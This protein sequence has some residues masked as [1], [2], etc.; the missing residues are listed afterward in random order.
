MSKYYKTISFDAK[1]Q[2]EAENVQKAI[3]QL[4]DKIE[5]K[6]HLIQLGEIISK[7]PHLIKKAI[8]YMKYL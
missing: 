2:Q 5:D 7:K 3:T 8:P 6:E 1:D 4:L